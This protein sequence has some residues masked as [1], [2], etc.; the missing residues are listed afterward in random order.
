M[1]KQFLS[2]T[3][4]ELRYIVRSVLMK[5]LNNQNLRNFELCSQESMN[6]PIW[7]IIGFQQK[8]RQDSQ[9]LKN[10]TFC[11][12]PVI[13]AQAFIGTEIY[14]DSSIL[15][16]Y[17]NDEYRQDY[18][19]VQEAFRAVT[20]NDILQPYLSDHDFGSS[21]VRVD[22]VGH[23]LYVFD[24]RYQQNFS[25][26]QPLKVKFKF[27]GVAPNE[28]NGYASVLTAKLF[29]IRSDGQRYFDLF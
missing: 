28:M 26:S 23:N 21:N 16:S 6:V 11:R 17:D 18:S 7:I 27:D 8:D 10:D 14:P 22:D 19:Q 25:A 29:F 3:P 2:K 12:L 13:S 15:L 1:S 5:E 4:T 20:N 9:N 24:T